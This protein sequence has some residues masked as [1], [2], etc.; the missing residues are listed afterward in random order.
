ML[1]D[2]VPAREEKAKRPFTGWMEKKEQ[3]AHSIVPIDNQ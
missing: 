2:G 1:Q 3:L